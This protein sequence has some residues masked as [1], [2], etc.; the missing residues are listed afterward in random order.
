MSLATH[1]EFVL[2]LCEWTSNGLNVTPFSSIW[3]NKENNNNIFQ[4][5]AYMFRNPYWF[6][7]NYGQN[8]SGND[9]Y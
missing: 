8:G 1:L 7:K 2:L 5:F 3:Y 6:H 4:L 9:R